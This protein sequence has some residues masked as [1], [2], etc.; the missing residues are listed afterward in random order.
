MSIQWSTRPRRTGA[1]LALALAA[2]A[3]LAPTVATAAT[4]PTSSTDMQFVEQ[5]AKLPQLS[6]KWGTARVVGLP[7]VPQGDHELGAVP[8]AA[9]A[10]AAY[11]GVVQ[12]DAPSEDALELHWEIE[13]IGGAPL[14]VLAVIPRLEEQGT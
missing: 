2:T 8:V 7:D 5:V 11:S 14:T 10:T 9:S 13:P 6:I 4:V 12:I 3:A 1:A